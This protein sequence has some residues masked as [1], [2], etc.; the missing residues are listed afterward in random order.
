MTEEQVTKT[1]LKFLYDRGWSIISFDFPQ[2]GTGKMLHPNDA[3]GEKNKGSITPDII[4]VKDHT[5][6]FFEN[7][8][9]FYL[10]DYEKINGL[11]VDN[12]Y[13]NDIDDLL[14]G[15]EIETIYYGIGLPTEKHTEKSEASAHLVHFILG[16]NADRSIAI[17]YNPEAIVF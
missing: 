14:A 5:A 12:Q 10:P 15:Y 3:K 8:D 13:T 1:F 11:I 4:V 2:S 7:K 16:V 17:L 6:L 9:R